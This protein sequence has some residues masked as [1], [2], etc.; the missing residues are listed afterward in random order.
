MSGE[1]FVKNYAAKES[2]RFIKEKFFVA[3]NLC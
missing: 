3:G 2:R 1:S